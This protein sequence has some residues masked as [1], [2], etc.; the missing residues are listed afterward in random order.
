MEVTSARI[1]I[2]KNNKNYIAIA[3]ITLDEQLIIND[4]KVRAIKDKY[5]LDFPRNKFAV[6]NGQSNIIVSN[7]LHR[8]IYRSI[9]NRLHLQIQMD[10]LSTWL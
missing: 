9:I 8:K 3:S 10:K 1:R 7:D 2:L 5:I 6:N 4:I